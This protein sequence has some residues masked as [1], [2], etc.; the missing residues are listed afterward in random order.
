MIKNKRAQEEMVGFALIIII[1]AIAMLFLL[2]FYI[3]SDRNEGAESYEVES[4]I[5]SSLHY[6]TDC[7]N[8]L[9]LF[10]MQKLITE[11][12]KDSLCQDKRKTCDVLNSTLKAVSDSS[13]DVGKDRP[14]KGYE[15]RVVAGQREL[16]SVKEG[17]NNGSYRGSSQTLPGS[18]EIFF[19]AYY[20]D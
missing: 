11:C 1:V 13:W 14:V 16:A 12:S 5:Q 15:I 8:F 20:A 4:F 19:R 18:I 10:S 2:V 3:R 9:G 7:G 17:L 6:T